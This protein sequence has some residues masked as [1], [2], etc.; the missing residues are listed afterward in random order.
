MIIPSNIV[1]HITLAISVK[2]TAFTYFHQ[3][4]SALVCSNENIEFVVNGQNI[5]N[6]Q[7]RPEKMIISWFPTAVFQLQL[8]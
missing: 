8:G 1:N 5:Q 2:I 4:R 6:H 3:N 7:Y